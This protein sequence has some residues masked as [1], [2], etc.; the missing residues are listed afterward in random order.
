MAGEEWTVEEREVGE[1]GIDVE[2]VG[3]RGAKV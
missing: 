2:E 3:K 1:R